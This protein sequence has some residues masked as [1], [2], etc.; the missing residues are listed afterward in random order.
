MRISV[1]AVLGLCALAPT[2]V[3]G[4]E[5][6]AVRFSAKPAAARAGEGAR[7]TFTVSAP[8]DVEV[9]VL[10]A[11]G[12]IVRHLAAGVVGGK[13]KPPAPLK[14]GLAQEIEWDGRDDAGK[15]VKGGP[16]KVRVRAGMRPEADGFLLENPASTGR[17][18]FLAVGPKGSVYVFHYDPTT[19]GHW[20]STKLKVLNRDGTHQRAIMPFPASCPPEKLKPVGVFRTESGD[21]VPHIRHLLRLA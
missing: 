12:K 13:G 5:A 8:T 11:D 1:L 6:E 21:V 20:G 14:A 9:A 19:V 18:R 10:G 2:V 7:V 15:P 3:I 17:I 4:G 16:F